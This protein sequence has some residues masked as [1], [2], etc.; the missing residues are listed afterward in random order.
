MPKSAITE[1]TVI[2][3]PSE[4]GNPV[5]FPFPMRYSERDSQTLVSLRRVK[6]G[7]L[8]FASNRSKAP[9]DLALLYQKAGEHARGEHGKQADGCIGC[10]TRVAEMRP[11]ILQAAGLMEAPVCRTKEY[12]VPAEMM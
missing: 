7:T 11:R 2:F 3:I 9:E 1:I 4:G 6:E 12:A 10:G 5:C 8:I